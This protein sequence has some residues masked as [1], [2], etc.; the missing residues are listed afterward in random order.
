MSTQP[1][2]RQPRPVDR[3]LL[4]RRGR[5]VASLGLVVGLGAVGTLAYWSDS[6]EVAGGTFTAGTLDLTVDGIDGEPGESTAFTTKFAAPNMKPGDSRA[7]DLQ[8]ANR[9][10]IDFEYVVSGVAPGEL[11]ETLVVSV[12]VGATANA[13][14]TACVGG[15]E[16]FS[17]HLGAASTAVVPQRRPLAADGAESL[18]VVASMPSGTT[19]GQGRS[20]TTS[21]T[22]E[23]TQVGA[24]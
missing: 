4:W 13:S 17:G 9:G 24:P 8:I 2:R 7:A 6:V 16:T 14:G 5:A 1:T 12:R 18:C 10:T 19:A 15:T 3:A 21:F 23:A 22:V 20:T 11:A